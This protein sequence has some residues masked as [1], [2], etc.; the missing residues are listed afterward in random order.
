MKVNSEG[1]KFTQ[2]KQSW[3]TDGS[4]EPENEQNNIPLV[5]E[6]QNVNIQQELPFI[7][8][9]DKTTKSLVHL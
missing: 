7:I 5:I 3:Y 6:T 1:V 4:G 8:G 2:G 9:Q